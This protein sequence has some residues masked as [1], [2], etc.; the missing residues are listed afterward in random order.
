VWSWHPLLVSSSWMADR[1]DRASDQAIHPRTM[2]AKRNSS[3]GR[4]RRTP[5]KPLRRGARRLIRHHL[6]SLPLCFLLHRGPRVERTPGLPCALRFRGGTLPCKARARRAARTRTCTSAP[7]RRGL[8]C[9]TNRKLQRAPAVA[10]ARRH[11]SAQACNAWLERDPESTPSGLSPMA[12]G[13]FSLVDKR[14]A[15]ARDHAQ[16]IKYEVIAR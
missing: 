13:G 11:L 10:S 3:P 4:A 1:P 9:L 5:L 2:V 7:S 15:F 16:I 8:G 6:W 14:E 12:P